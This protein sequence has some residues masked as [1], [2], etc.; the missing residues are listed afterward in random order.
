[1]IG[2]DLTWLRPAGLAPITNGFGPLKIELDYAPPA[3]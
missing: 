3:L 2:N 1:M